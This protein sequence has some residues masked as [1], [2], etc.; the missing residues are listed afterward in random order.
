VQKLVVKNNLA[1]EGLGKIK[2]KF[3]TIDG[4]GPTWVA[5]FL[6]L[7]DPEERARIQREAFELINALMQGVG[8]EPF[9]E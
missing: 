4:V 1:K 2:A 3:T 9:S 6:E 7:S 8:I 5:D